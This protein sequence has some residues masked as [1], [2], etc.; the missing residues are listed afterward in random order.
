MAVQE[1][2]TSMFEVEMEGAAQYEAWQEYQA[3]QRA[4]AA[5]GRD[6]DVRL[7]T[8]PMMV[9]DDDHSRRFDRRTDSLV[10]VG[11]DEQ[12]QAEGWDRSTIVLTSAQVHRISALALD[13]DGDVTIASTA[14]PL[15]A[16]L[17]AFELDGDRRLVAV[18]TDGSTRNASP[19]E[20]A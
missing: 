13:A 7:T 8:V 5:A 15:D 9:S 6:D 1:G 16:A 11:D 17:V 12:E 14:Q 18:F 10:L 19:P 2:A 4:E 3:E 20:A